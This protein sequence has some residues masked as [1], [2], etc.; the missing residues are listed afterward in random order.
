LT[1]RKEAP[2]EYWTVESATGW[3]RRQHLPEIHSISKGSG[4]QSTIMAYRFGEVT[5][6]IFSMPMVIN[7]ETA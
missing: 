2:S 6:W 4:T 5:A 7:E 3:I 1:K